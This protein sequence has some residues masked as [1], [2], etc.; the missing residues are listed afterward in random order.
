MSISFFFYFFLFQNRIHIITSQRDTSS[1]IQ[2]IPLLEIISFIRKRRGSGEESRENGRM[3][4]KE[5]RREIDSLFIYFIVIYFDCIR[6]KEEA[7]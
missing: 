2:S 7:R 4:R 6:F 5:K 1:L 3:E